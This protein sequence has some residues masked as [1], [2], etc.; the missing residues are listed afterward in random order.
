MDLVDITLSTPNL[1][2]GYVYFFN[3]LELILHECAEKLTGPMCHSEN[4]SPL[5]KIKDL[6]VKDGHIPNIPD[7]EFQ[8][9]PQ[10]VIITGDIVYKY[11]HIYNVNIDRS[12]I[13]QFNQIIDNTCGNPHRIEDALYRKSKYLAT[14]NQGGFINNYARIMNNIEHR[15]PRNSYQ[16]FKKDIIK[17]IFQR[18]QIDFFC[19]PYG[20]WRLPA[21]LETV[22]P[23]ALKNGI[24][25]K[26]FVET[27]EEPADASNPRRT[28]YLNE[29][30]PIQCAPG[31]RITLQNEQQLRFLTFTKLR[32]LQ[33]CDNIMHLIPVIKWIECLYRLFIRSR[34]GQEEIA[35]FIAVLSKEFREYKRETRIGNEHPADVM[36]IINTVYSTLHIGI[37]TDNSQLFK[38]INRY[39]SLVKN[40]LKNDIRKITCF[41]CTADNPDRINNCYREIT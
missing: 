1:P 12:Y 35:N 41:A 11:L 31:H 34:T 28:I 19:Q 36:R 40:N 17:V 38:D 24:Y 30:L 15:A 10:N 32:Q 20:K 25:R 3:E 7:H 39:T 4:T 37:G 26:L 5:Y 8:I 21:D 23:S 33:L 14:L 18:I 22:S 9:I 6:L 29:N 13:R 16:K 27:V 2:P